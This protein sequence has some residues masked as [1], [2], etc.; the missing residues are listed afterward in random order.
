MSLS[1]KNIRDFFIYM[2]PKFIG[3]GITLLTLPVLTR[4]LAPEDFGVVTMTTLFSTLGASVLTLGITSAAQRYYFE[5]KPASAEQNALLFTTQLFLYLM[6]IV[7]GVTVYFFRDNI[8]LLITGNAGYGTAVFMMFTAGYLGQITTFYLY[9]YQNMRKAVWHSAFTIMKTVMTGALSILLVWYFKMSYMGLI[10]ASLVSAGAVCLLMFFMFN[11]KFRVLLSLPVFLENLRYGLQVV[12]KSLTGFVNMYF[13][14]YM[15]NNLL[16]LSAVG[17]YNIGQNVG[18]I[19]FFLMGAI[20][21]S[22]QPVYYKEVFDRGEA[23]STSVGRMFTIFSYVCLAP[24]LLLILFAGEVLFIVAPPAYYGALDVI[25]VIS[26]GVATQVFGIYVGVQYAYSKKAYWLFPIS[27]AGAVINIVTNIILIP[28]YGLVGGAISSSLGTAVVNL[29]LISI[30]QRL[31]RIGYEWKTLAA[32]F[33]IISAAILSAFFVRA[34]G[35][36]PAVVYAPKLALLA[37][38]IFAGIR[39]RI[40]TQASIEKLAG[41]LFNYRRKAA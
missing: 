39:A 32:F 9:M 40:V 22:F 29:L 27:V 12:P 23:A 7:S 18:N 8:A 15:I 14:K 31:Y 38:Y 28:R 3:Y 30:G 25:I 6:L 1:E 13:D 5:Y 16:S 2:M 4:I 37:L 20:W 10:W 41:S 19:V 17:V 33:S 21:A 34:D 11:R 24:L 35:F 26:A 36:S